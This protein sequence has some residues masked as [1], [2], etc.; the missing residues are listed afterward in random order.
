MIDM[1]LRDSFDLHKKDSWRDRKVYPL[2]ED[3]K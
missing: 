1:D 3:K 2:S